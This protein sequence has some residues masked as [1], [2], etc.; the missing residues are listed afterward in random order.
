MCIPSDDLIHEASPA[1]ELVRRVSEYFDAHTTTE[2]D[3]QLS[4]YFDAP[5]KQRPLCGDPWSPSETLNAWVVFHDEQAGCK[6]DL[7]RGMEKNG[8]LQ[9]VSKIG[10]VTS[11]TEL[12][13]LLQQ[14]KTVVERKTDRINLRVFRSGILPMWEDLHNVD[15]GECVFTFP[16]SKHG[17]LIVRDLMQSIISSDVF[18]AADINGVVLSSRSWGHVL[19]LWIGHMAGTCG[20]LEQ[21]N[22]KC[23]VCRVL[24]RYSPKFVAFQSARDILARGEGSSLHA[25]TSKD[26]S[27]E[28]TSERSGQAT[29]S[30]LPSTPPSAP[31][32]ASRQLRQ[33]KGPDG[34]I[35]FA[36]FHSIGRQA[37]PVYQNIRMLNASQPTAEADAPAEKWRCSCGW[38]NRPSN[39]KCGGGHPTFGCGKLPRHKG[40]VRQNDCKEAQH[41]PASNK[42]TGNMR[43]PLFT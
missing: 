34:T 10:S 5:E 29:P 21:E 16:K 18:G 28:S 17:A 24:C 25:F 38:M 12:D 4:E 23:S 19:H 43:P 27:D 31:C 36:S 37:L 11:V 9:H 26:A 42:G 8:F 13:A 20:I 41:T 22:L 32:M 1:E 7:H 14:R 3:R 2:I 35:G 33:P 6:K 39:R 40:S 15:G 30:S